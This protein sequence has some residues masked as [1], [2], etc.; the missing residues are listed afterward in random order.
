MRGG[1]SE[2]RLNKGKKI[3]KEVSTKEEKHVIGKQNGSKKGKLGS[4]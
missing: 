3:G 2:G 4:V 1:K